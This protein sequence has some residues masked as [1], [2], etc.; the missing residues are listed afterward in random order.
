MALNIYYVACLVFLFVALF[1][2]RKS[3]Y[4]SAIL[5]FFISVNIIVIDGLLECGN[6]Y[7]GGSQSN[8]THYRSK[9]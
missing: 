1:G 3:F 4:H 7:Y 2:D 6:Y 5:L 8:V 9:G